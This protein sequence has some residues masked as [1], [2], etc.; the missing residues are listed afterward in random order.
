MEAAWDSGA[1][2]GVE[3]AIVPGDGLSAAESNISRTLQKFSHKLPSGRSPIGL[4][5]S[6]NEAASSSLRL[7][8]EVIPRS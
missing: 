5:A 3:D 1:E 8:A 2:A 4:I 7:L 6:K